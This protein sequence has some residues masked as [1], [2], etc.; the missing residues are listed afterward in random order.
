MPGRPPANFK[1]TVA[2]MREAMGRCAEKKGG[3]GVKCRG[4]DGEVV[5]GKISE[6]GVEGFGGF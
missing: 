4:R 2:L 6:I 1:P 5:S 3:G